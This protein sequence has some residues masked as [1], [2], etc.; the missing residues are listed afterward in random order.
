MLLQT[1][2]LTITAAHGG[3]NTSAFEIPAPHLFL[4]QYFY[5]ITLYYS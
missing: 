2:I 5:F 4:R 1:C 3:A